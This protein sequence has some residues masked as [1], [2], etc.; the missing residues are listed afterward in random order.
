VIPFSS[1]E[2]TAEIPSRELNAVFHK[3]LIIRDYQGFVVLLPVYSNK[4][5]NTIHANDCTYIVNYKIYTI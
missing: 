1:Y 2:L 4:R 3:A 5:L